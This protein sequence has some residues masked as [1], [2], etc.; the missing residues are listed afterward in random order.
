MVDINYIF[1]IYLVKG[2]ALSIP[3]PPREAILSSQAQFCGKV[4]RFPDESLALQGMN[5]SRFGDESLAPG[6]ESLALWG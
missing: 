3:Q 1:V 2:G 6:D 5:R 4:H